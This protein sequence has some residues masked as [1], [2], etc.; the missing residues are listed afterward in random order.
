[1]WGTHIKYFSTVVKY[2]AWEEWTI[3]L[4]TS[5]EL[6]IKSRTWM[7]KASTIN[8]TSGTEQ[9]ECQVRTL[10]L[11]VLGWV[12]A[13]QDVHLWKLIIFLHL[14][15]AVFG[16]HDK[17]H[18]KVKNQAGRLFQNYSPKKWRWQD[19]EGIL[20]RHDSEAAWGWGAKLIPAILKN[21]LHIQYLKMQLEKLN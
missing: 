11:S 3:M 17:L 20:N 5:R 10:P 14:N 19:R 2:R 1:M 15:A 16:M 9:T 13:W 18:V 7:S 8:A 4:N 12:W 21:T 6:A